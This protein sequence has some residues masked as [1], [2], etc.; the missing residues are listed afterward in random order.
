LAEEITLWVLGR[1][2]VVPSGKWPSGHTPRALVRFTGPVQPAWRKAMAEQQLAVRFWCPPRG[3]CVDLPEALRRA[4][5]R[6]EQLDFIAGACDYTEAMCLRETAGAALLPAD[7]LDVICFDAVARAGVQRLLQQRGIEVLQAASTK[8]RVRHA[9]AAEL[10]A[11]AGVKVVGR[12]R[13]PQLLSTGAVVHALGADAARGSSP[14]DGAGEVIAIADTGLDRG[15]AGAS[16]HADFAGRVKALIAMPMNPSW[17]GFAEARSDDAADRASGH[18]TLVAGL[19]LGSGAASGGHHRGVAPAA[20]LVF[21]ALEQDVRVLPGSM[22]RLASGHYLAGRPLDLRD[23]YR[24]AS[25]RGA[26]LHNLSWGD[27]ARGTY[28]DDCHET[29][30]FLNEQPLSV[31]VC[32]AGND[33]ADRDGNRRIDA[34]SMRAPACAKN[35]IAV[36]ATEGPLVGQGSRA[37]WGQLDPSARRWPVFS[38]RNDPVSG[39]PDRIAPFSAAGPTADGRTKPELCAPGTNLVGARSQVCTGRGWGLA[40]PMPLYMYEGGTSMA[41]PLVTGALALLR[42]AWRQA[43]Q[44]QRRT[45][46]GA[47]LKALLL[48]GCAPVRSRGPGSA[49][50]F[51]AGFGRIDLARSLPPGRGG[52]PGWTVTLR[53]AVSQQLDTGEQREAIVRLAAA[54]RL[55]AVLCWYDAA[56]ERLINDLDLE[57]LGPAGSVLALGAAPGAPAPDRLNP[58]ELIDV[59]ALPA[60]RYRLRVRGHNVMDGPQRYALAWAVQTPAA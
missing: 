22:A 41:A 34:G 19:A 1:T 6:L 25:A 35:V 43:W 18:G 17:A 57:L 30:L 51:E 45:P 4:P 56:G 7:L 47:A 13:L 44:R 21:Q 50:P 40:D 26:T 14:L 38:E 32:A 46:S 8:L 10:R 29:D 60:G 53:D 42:Q 48:L 54:S 20:S 49:T 55:R 59:P 16:L 5:Q 12:V 39:E 27:D 31:V 11:I 15:D 36:G 23:L 9:D 52:V 33:G 28:T 58:V 2:V 37:T 24:E 3:A